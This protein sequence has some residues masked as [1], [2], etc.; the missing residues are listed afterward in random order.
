M[1]L[2]LGVADVPYTN[3]RSGITTGDVAEILE[4]KYHPMEIFSEIHGDDIADAVANGMAGEIENL[5][6]GAPASPNPFQGGETVID[7]MFKDFLA[8]KEMDGLGYPGVPTMAAIKGINHRMKGKRTPGR[9]S[10]IDTG[11]YQASFKSWV[12]EFDYANAA[13]S[14]ADAYAGAF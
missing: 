12:D 2:H 1:K 4:A 14:G 6:I 5:I 11:L 7:E 9:P 8:N 13:Q 3:D 10:F